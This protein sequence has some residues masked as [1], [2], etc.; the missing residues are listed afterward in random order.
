MTLPVS[1][2]VKAA[3]SNPLG[4]AVLPQRGDQVRYRAWR[5]D[6]DQHAARSLLDE[7]MHEGGRT[8]VK[9]LSVVHDE[10]QLAVRPGSPG[11]GVVGLPEQPQQPC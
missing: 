11:D 3:R 7:L 5:S 2:S 10:Q 4:Q 6:N 1:G 8:L 9:V